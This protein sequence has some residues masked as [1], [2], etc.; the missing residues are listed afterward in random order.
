VTCDC[1]SPESSVTVHQ[2]L[3]LGEQVTIHGYTPLGTIGSN[4]LQLAPTLSAPYTLACSQARLPA[5]YS[6]QHFEKTVLLRVTSIVDNRICLVVAVIDDKFLRGQNVT[7][8]KEKS[9]KQPRID[10]VRNGE[11]MRK[12]GTGTDN[13]D[14]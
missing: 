6:L 12:M 5:G 10:C 3:I 7:K 9:E 11:N 13:V 1:D 14:L 4:H 2:K 8:N